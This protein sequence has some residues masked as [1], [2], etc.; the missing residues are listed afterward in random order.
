[1]SLSSASLSNAESPADQAETLRKMARERQIAAAQSAQTGRQARRT[2][3]FTFTSGKG[4][5]GKT[6]VAANVAICLSRM[7]KSVL[8]L[9]ADLGLANIDVV[10]GLDSD[11]DLSHVIHGEKTLKDVIIEGPEGIRVIPAASGDESLADLDE[12]GRMSLL[13]QFEALEADFDYLLIDSSAGISSNVIFF[14]LAAQS[15]IIVATPEPTSITDAYAVIK[16][17]SQEH[18][19]S[20]FYLAVNRAKNPTEGREVHETLTRVADRFLKSVTIECLGILPDDPRINRAIRSREPVVTAYRTASITV[21]LEKL[22]QA[23]A[24]IPFEDRN[25]GYPGILR[26]RSL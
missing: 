24:R 21:A 5:V 26:N 14:N 12:N 2:R 11:Y 18:N 22:T 23:I 3:I 19:V 1:M 9:D 17:L 13:A 4:G 8:V 6:L 15:S 10:L 25:A 16:V 20:H 7:G